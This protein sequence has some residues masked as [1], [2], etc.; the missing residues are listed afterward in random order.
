MFSFFL[1]RHEHTL[2]FLCITSTLT[3]SLEN[4]TVYVSYVLFKLPSNKSTPSTYSEYSKFHLNPNYLYWK[5]LLSY[6]KERLKKNGD[7]ASPDCRPLWIGCIGK[8]FT[9]PD[10][11][12]R[13]IW[14][15]SILTQSVPRY[16]RFREDITQNIP[17]VRIICSRQVNK[18]LLYYRTVFRFFQISW[19]GQNVLSGTHVRR[20][21]R[22]TYTRTY[23]DYY[24]SHFRK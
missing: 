12:I 13:F 9:Y 16:V 6:F 2:S 15:R 19:W 1:S 18:Q 23:T 7:K 17:P 11:S 5:F 14:T 3:S 24:N 20:R 10:Y 8:M 22:F 4:I 21:S